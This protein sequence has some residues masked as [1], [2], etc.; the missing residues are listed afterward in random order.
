ME[1]VAIGA[2]HD[3]RFC[4]GRRFRCWQ[5]EVSR[6]ADISREED[7]AVRSL[8]YVNECARRSE[9]VARIEEGRAHAWQKINRLAVLRSA[10]EPADAVH[11]VDDGIERRLLHSLV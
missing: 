1:L 11:Y 3:H 9:N 8:F 6:I 5:Q 4:S 2:L 7:A 10:A